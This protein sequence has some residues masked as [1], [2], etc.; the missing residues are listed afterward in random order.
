MIILIFFD[1][2]DTLNHFDLFDVLSFARI[3]LDPFDPFIP[4]GLSPPVL[5]Y[6]PFP[7][8][9]LWTIC[10]SSKGMREMI[11]VAVTE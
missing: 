1:L 6:L 2:F 5:G 8:R 3:L 7:F 4:A 11:S 9:V 10:F